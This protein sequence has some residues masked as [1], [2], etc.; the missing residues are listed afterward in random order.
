MPQVTSFTAEQIGEEII[1]KMEV[2]EGESVW[3]G[4]KPVPADADLK[5]EADILAAEI[6]E[7]NTTPEVPAAQPDPVPVDVSGIVVEIK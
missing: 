5:V 2:T 6:L 1:L 3:T 4:I 7:A